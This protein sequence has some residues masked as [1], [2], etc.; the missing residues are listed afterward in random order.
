MSVPVVAVVVNL[1]ICHVRFVMKK[2]LFCV[3]DVAEMDAADECS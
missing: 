3:A 2:V 1:G